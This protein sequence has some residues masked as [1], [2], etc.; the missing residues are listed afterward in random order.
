MIYRSASGTAEAEDGA[1][2]HW[3]RLGTDYAA[4]GSWHGAYREFLQRA[5]GIQGK[6]I[7]DVGAACGAQLRAML[8]G[9]ADAFGAEPDHWMATHGVRGTEGRLWNCYVEALGGVEDFDMVHSHQVLEHVP[10]DR[11][12]GHFAAFARHLK[13]GGIVYANLCLGGTPGCTRDKT[14]ITLQPREWWAARA[15]E[16]GLEDASESF[17][18]VVDSE[19]MQRSMK[20]DWFVWR[21]P[22]KESAK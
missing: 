18:G 4:Y 12:P 13:P 15:A 8:A 19:P 7:L 20:W 16:A 3:R 2:Q 14:H 17:R 11:V 6:R 21:K 5:F 22:E 9:G 1:Y 10:E